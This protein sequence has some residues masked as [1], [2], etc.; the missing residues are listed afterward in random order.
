MVSW[1]VWSVLH[2]AGCPSSSAG[3]GHWIKEPFS[4]GGDW[5]C[6]SGVLTWN[7]QASRESRAALR[8]SALEVVQSLVPW[9]EETAEPRK[10]CCCLGGEGNWTQ[11]PPHLHL[12]DWA[13]PASSQG[14]QTLLCSE[15]LRREFLPLVYSS[16]LRPG[17]CSLLSA[18]LQTEASRALGWCHQTPASSSG[19][20]LSQT[21]TSV[22]SGHP[23]TS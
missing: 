10:G 18:N 1:W 22:A 4:P 2:W 21:M 16:L 12:I 23:R 15:S 9:P 11:F 14:P 19:R 7:E 20:V 6:K 5:K 8:C 17:V 3:P 13:L